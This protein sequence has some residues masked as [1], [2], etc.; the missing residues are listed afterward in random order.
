M[1]LDGS[2]NVLLP[3]AN[4]ATTLDVSSE[5]ATSTGFDGDAGRGRNLMEISA[6]ALPSYGSHDGIENVLQTTLITSTTLHCPH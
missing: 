6:E 4:S 1:T 5:V 3:P 2:T